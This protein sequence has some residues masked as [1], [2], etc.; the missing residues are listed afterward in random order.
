M[1]GSEVSF[2]EGGSRTGVVPGVDGRVRQNQGESAV[3]FARRVRPS[4]TPSSVEWIQIDAAVQSRPSPD[5]AGSL[6]AITALVDGYRAEHIDGKPRGYRVL[7][8][9]KE[10]LFTKIY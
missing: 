8:V 3:E 1:W 9:A 2:G 6:A 4:K 5:C 7:A 10:A